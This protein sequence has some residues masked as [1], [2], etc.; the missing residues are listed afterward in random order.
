M[1]VTPITATPALPPSPELTRVRTSVRTGPSFA[2]VLKGGLGIIL[3]GATAAAGPVGGALLASAVRTGGTPTAAPGGTA[4]SAASV[5]GGGAG[6][7]AGGSD[8][9]MMS[10]MR[11]LQA[12][13]RDMNLEMLALQEQVQQ[14]NRRFSTASNVLK[15]RHDTA[16][17]AIGNIRP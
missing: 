4:G 5:L 1:P 11:D 3:T 9:D 7:G 6:T 16:K 17:A 2:D 15:A 12:Q 13:S 10:Q 14:E 8:G